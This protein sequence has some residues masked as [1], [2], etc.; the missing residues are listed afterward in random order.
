M[1]RDHDD[2]IINIR[3]SCYTSHLLLSL[4]LKKNSLENLSATGN[5]NYSCS[6][7]DSM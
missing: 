6:H 1:S 4:N 3:A 2:S 5:F 7:S